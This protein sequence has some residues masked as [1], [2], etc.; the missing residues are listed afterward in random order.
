MKPLEKSKE[1]IA[2]IEVGRREEISS[3]CK[4]L[5]SEIIYTVTKGGG[6]CG[7]ENSRGDGFQSVNHLNK[8]S[9]YSA[10]VGCSDGI[11]NHH[12]DEAHYPV[13]SSNFSLLSVKRR[14]LTSLFF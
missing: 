6:G 11:E 12:I 3:L 14:L 1:F 8:V 4:F 5:S 10:L 9:L 2:F 13:Y 7:E